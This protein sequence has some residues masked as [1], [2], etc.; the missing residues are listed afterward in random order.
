MPKKRYS[1][2]EIIH[3]LRET[4]VL[5]S[6][7]K[8][9]TETCKRLTVTEQTYNRWRKAYSSMK[10]DKAKRLKELEAF[11]TTVQAVC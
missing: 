7:E 2:E 10:V 3:K 9:V 4:D 8:S 5:L 11:I 1:A 6:Q